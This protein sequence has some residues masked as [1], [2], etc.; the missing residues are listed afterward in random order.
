MPTLSDS[1]RLTGWALIA[2]R[3][4][5]IMKISHFLSTVA[6]G[7]VCVSLPA[8]NGGGGGGKSG[9]NGNQETIEDP[10]T[11]G[12]T[13]QDY[14]PNDLAK[15][16]MIWT[17]SDNVDHKYS[18]N[19]SSTLSCGEYRAGTNTWTGFII[20]NT[21]HMNSYGGYFVYKKTSPTTATISIDNS[22]QLI[23]ATYTNLVTIK[24][25]Y[26][27]QFTSKTSATFTRTGVKNYAGGDTYNLYNIGRAT[28]TFPN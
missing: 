8:C 13:S 10:T 11:P 21:W 23:N 22:L 1:F 2:A 3:I 25:T 5:L 24:E 7:A 20:G 9:N 14:A 4:D 6:L 18:F 26:E 17:G 27:L 19:S 12:S 15:S 16:T 28:F